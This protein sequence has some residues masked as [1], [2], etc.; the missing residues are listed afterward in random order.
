LSLNTWIKKYHHPELETSKR[1]GELPVH[2]QLKAMKKQL[3]RLT[4]ERDILKKAAAYFASQS[5]QSTS[6]LS[7]SGN[8][9]IRLMCKV[10]EV[11]ASAYYDWRG[12]PPS[13]HKVEDKLLIKKIEDIHEQH[14]GNYGA[15][16][17]RNDLFDDSDVS[18]VSRQHVARLM[19]EE[20][21][22]AW[23]IIGPQQKCIENCQHNMIEPDCTLESCRIVRRMGSPS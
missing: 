23:V 5:S 16:C 1:A 13:K 18:C 14:K 19:R 17:I 21:I 8:H 10:L 2:D 7:E 6:I 4:E 11:S 12:R 22:Q 15:R 3:K 20:G 9:T